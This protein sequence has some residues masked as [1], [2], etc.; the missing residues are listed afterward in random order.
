MFYSRPDLS[1]IP[2]RDVDQL[3]IAL[4]RLQGNDTLIM[5]AFTDVVH[6]VAQHRASKTN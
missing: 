3:Q 6:E 5:H 4:G 1:W 2:I